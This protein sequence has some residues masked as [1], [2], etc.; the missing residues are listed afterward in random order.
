MYEE[1]S[2]KATK[3]ISFNTRDEF[4]RRPIA[5]KLIKIIK[6][7][8]DVS[9]MIIDGNWGTG[10]SEF[11]TKLVTLL[12]E[13]SDYQPIY[14]DAFKA[15]HTEEPFLTILSSILKLVPD[16]EQPDLIK[17]IMPAVR[18]GLKTTMKAGVS[19]LLKQDATAIT[20]GFDSDLKKAGDVI[21][22][23][24]IQTL[25]S[26]HIQADQNLET[27][28]T[29][30]KVISKDKPIVVFI[31]ELDRCRPDFAVAI[32][33]NIKHIFNVRNVHFVL[34]TNTKQLINSIHHRYG[35][36]LD[37]KQYLD[38][39]VKFSFTLPEQY[40]FPNH[41][42]FKRASVTYFKNLFESSTPL[43]NSGNTDQLIDNLIGP[44]IISNN[45]SLRQVERF[46]QHLQ[47]YKITN[48][49]FLSN[50]EA[51]AWQL[52]KV[53]GVYLYVFEAQIVE[54]L[55]SEIVDTGAIS[56]LMG[57]DLLNSD[58]AHQFHETNRWISSIVYLVH[59]AAKESLTPKEAIL[60]PEQYIAPLQADTT[61]LFNN[62]YPR[63]GHSTIIFQDV[64][65]SLSLVD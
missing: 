38:K 58:L 19:W 49:K 4:N 10:K 46:I 7:D 61:R 17:K 21:I 30:L 15:D 18:F 6:S 23:G 11:C 59:L 42:P 8:I 2:I 55:R 51:T 63:S 35:E 20:D 13:E 50:E 22:D 1:N 45:L 12:K 24:S 62:N 37:A 26:D 9:P 3:E 53:L 25:L 52:L 41:Q 36:K 14:I 54:E 48:D 40:R 39:F 31:D 28:A 29:V 32:L 47:V 34:V 43:K 64:F 16:K 5:D 44:L 33:E 57:V 56:K 60:I 27:L 65:N